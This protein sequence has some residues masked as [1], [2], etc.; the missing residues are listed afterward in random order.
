MGRGLLAVWKLNLQ[1][2]QADELAVD[3]HFSRQERW[4]IAQLPE[5]LQKEKSSSLLSPSMHIRHMISELLLLNGLPPNWRE[6]CI[7]MSIVFEYD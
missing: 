3:N 5:H 4:A 1:I 6:S 2:S 7:F